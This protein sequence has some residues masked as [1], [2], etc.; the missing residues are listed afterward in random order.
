[1]LKRQKIK[2]LIL[3]S[4]VSHNFAHFASREINMILKKSTV[5]ERESRWLGIYGLALSFQLRH[6]R[7]KHKKLAAPTLHL[8]AFYPHIWS[9]LQKNKN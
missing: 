8:L 7:W 1:M 2:P 3:I 9:W 6:F 5:A 4:V